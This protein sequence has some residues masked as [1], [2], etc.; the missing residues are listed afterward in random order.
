VSFTRLAELV[1]VAVGVFLA[2]LFI[3]D[4]TP[5][6]WLVRAS[7]AGALTAGLAAVAVAVGR[8]VDGA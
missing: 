1:V 8:I 4:E 2:V 5:P 3:V 6:D 7:F